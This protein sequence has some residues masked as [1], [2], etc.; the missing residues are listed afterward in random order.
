[1]KSKEIKR[2][3]T[4]EDKAIEKSKQV[5][6]WRKAYNTL[7]LKEREEYKRLAIKYNKEVI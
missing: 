5:D 2:M 1:M 4:L 3:K 7:S 6:D